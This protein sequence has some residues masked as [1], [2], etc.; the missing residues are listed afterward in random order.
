MNAEITFARQ[1]TQRIDGETLS[2]QTVL[3]ARRDELHHRL[4]QGASGSEMITVFTDLVD[5]V[6]ISRYEKVIRQE[7]AEVLLGL[8]HCCLVAVGGYGRRELAPYS[9]IDVMVLFQTGGG[10]VVSS[11]SSQVFYHLWDL[12]F[13][14]GHSV[15]TIQEGLA[16]AEGDLSTRTALMESR[17]LAGNRQVFQNFTRRF[18][19]KILGRRPDGFI[20]GKREERRREYAKFGETVY[21]LEPNIKKT[22]GGLRDLHLLQWV[23]MAK[24]QASTLRELADRG[25]LANQDYLAL[26]EAREFLW[27]VR[28]FL[29][30]YAGRAQDILT[31]DEQVRVAAHFGFSDRPHLLAVEQFMQRYY[32]H[33]TGI[34]DRC[35]RFLDRAQERRWWKKIRQI[36]PISLVA[37][38]FQISGARVTVPSEKVRYILDH[39]DVLLE[40]FQLAQKQ[41][42]TVDSVVLDELSRQLEGSQD[43]AY[44]IPLVSQRFRQILSGPKRIADTLEAMHRARLLEKIIPAFGRVRGLMQFNQYHKYTVDEHSVLAVRQAEGLADDQGLLGDVYRDMRNKDL[45]HLALLLHDLG[46]GLPGDHSEVG[47][48]I[49]QDTASRLGFNPQ[50]TRTLEFLVHQHLLMAH[51]AFRRDPYDEKVLLTFA[52]AVGTPDILRKLYVLTIADIAAVGPQTLTKWK[53]SLLAELFCRTLPEVSGGR[54]GIT[55]PVDIARLAEE[56]CQALPESVASHQMGKADVIDAEWVQSQLTQFPIRY[57]SGTPPD[58]IA[59]HLMAINQLTP[60]DPIVTS[61]YHPSLN[62][63]EYT[64]VVYDRMIPGIFMHVSGGLAAKGLEVLDAQIITREDGIVIDSFFATDPDFQGAPS[65]QRLDNVGQTI[66]R[67]LKGND[68]VAQLMGRNHRLALSQPFPHDQFQ[69]EVHIDNE[70]SATFT[71]IDVFAEN[72]Q[73]LLYVM[74][75][76]IFNLG[77]VLHAARISTRLDQVVD[78]F[79]VT[80]DAGMKVDDTNVRESVRKT[81]RQDVDQFL[82]KSKKNTTSP[83][84]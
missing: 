34:H 66:T 23:G 58:R 31:F 33:T 26:V 78:V 63:C 50:E 65:A 2:A 3:Q 16:I 60:E 49:A 67:I 46:K 55:A 81:V 14:V 40:L 13:Q 74:A 30:F 45:L 41:S 18:Q 38:C 57:V 36:M 69:T 28:A 56:V 84:H 70:T 27:R 52:K 19:R 25:V 1:Q 68:S 17:F 9:D 72:R 54:E 53:E 39:P 5:A 7:T 76:S 21:L 77:L 73:G 22:K 71:L 44:R 47:K 15:R 59:A 24:Y 83:S 43:D 37:E 75:C 11:L 6:L 4:L 48:E 62:I 42:L 35:Q 64:L 82:E 10:N 20:N 29:H 80:N 79:Y 12:G 51:T 32:R 61:A 8:Q